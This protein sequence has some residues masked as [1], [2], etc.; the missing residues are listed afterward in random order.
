[1]K[2]TKRLLS[3]LL[4]VCM[5]L[6]LLPTVALFAGAAIDSSATWTQ[7]SWADIEDGATIIIAN[8]NHVALP[9]TTTSTNPTKV[10][11]TVSGS[12]GALTIT[13]ASGSLDSLAWTINGDTSSADGVQILQYGSTTVNLRLSSTSSNTALRVAATASDNKFVL[14]N[15]GRLL[16]LQTANRYVG[17]YVN[18]SDWRTYDSETAQNYKNQS[19]IF[20]KLNS[21]AAPA[22]TYTLSYSKNGAIATAD[23]A[24]GE[25]ISLPSAENVEDYHFVGWTA[26]QTVSGRPADLMPAGT[27]YTVNGDVMLYAVYAIA[28]E[29]SGDTF[30]LVDAADVIAGEYVIG[31]LRSEAATDAFYFA[32]GTV[33]SGDMVVTSDP[34]TVHAVNGIRTIGQSDLPSGTKIFTLTGD[35]AEGFAIGLDS[36]Y[37]GYTNGET[38]RTLDLGDYSSIRWTVLDSTKSPNLDEKGVHLR[39]GSAYTISENSTKTD[40]IRGYKGTTLYRPIYLFAR[41]AGGVG[42]SDYTTSPVEPESH[43]ITWLSEGETFAIAHW[44]DGDTILPPETNPVKAAADDKFYTFV[45][46]AATEGGELVTDFGVATGDRT[47]YAVFLE[48]TMC[49]VDDSAELTG[50]KSISIDVLAND[51][52]LPTDGVIYG[53]GETEADIAKR[54]DT[55]DVTISHYGTVTVAEGRVIY[56]PS[57]FVADGDVI[58]FYYAVQDALGGVDY[59]QV[60]VTARGM[61]NDRPDVEPGD[62]VYTL[63]TQN[64]VP[65]PEVY[66]F[67]GDYILMGRLDADL[68]YLNSYQVLTPKWDADGNVTI[69]NV[70]SDAANNASLVDLSEIDDQGVATGSILSAYTAEDVIRMETSGNEN[71]LDG[72][73]NEYTIL[74]KITAIDTR[75]AFTIELVDD[76]NRYYTIRIKD[77]N[78]YLANSNTA[79]AGENVMEY[80]NSA[81]RNDT[82]MLWTI[83][84]ATEEDGLSATDG[85]T[86]D[87]LL[88]EN[89]YGL[90]QEEAVSRAILYNNQGG[91]DVTANVN[92]ARFRIYGNGAYHNNDYTLAGA[93]GGISYSIYLFGAPVPFV[94]QIQQDGEVKTVA[95]PVT[96]SAGRTADVDLQS[97]LL[98]DIDTE[99]NYELTGAPVWTISGNSATANGA[100]IRL[101]DSNEGTFHIGAA[102]EGAYAYVTVTYTVYDKVND[103]THRVSTDARIVITAATQSF[104]GVIYTGAEAAPNTVS[105]NVVSGTLVALDYYVVDNMT[106]L[107]SLDTAC[108]FAVNTEL[109]SDLVWSAVDTAGTV[110]TVSYD[111][112]RGKWTVDTAGA[113]AGEIISVTMTGA[114][115]KL[116]LNQDFSDIVNVPGFKI[117]VVDTLQLVADTAILS[118]LNPLTMDV[119]ANDLNLYEGAVICGLGETAALASLLQTVNVPVGAYGTVSVAENRV[120]FSPGSAVKENDVITFYY[121]VQGQDGSYD[122]ARVTITVDGIS[123]EGILTTDTLVIDFGLPVSFRPTANDTGDFTDAAVVGIQATADGTASKA[124][125]FA[126]GNA[127][128]H[129]D[130]TVTFTPTGMMTAPVVFYYAVQYK[131]ESFAGMIQIVPATNVYYEDSMD[132]VFTF[133]PAEAWARIGTTASAEQ[134]ADFAGDIANGIYGYD[135]AYQRFATYSMG[136]AHVAT[137]DNTTPM[138]TV[139]FD[140]YGSGFDVV[141]LTGGNSGYLMVAICPYGSSVPVARYVVDTYYGFSYSEQ[142]EQVYREETDEEGNVIQVPVY[143]FT[144]VGQ[145]NGD[146]ELCSGAA[147]PDDA[148]VWEELNGEIYYYRNVGEGEGSYIREPLIHHW[149]VTPETAQDFYQIPVMKVMGLEPA[150]YTVT[151]ASYYNGF[152]DHVGDGSYQFV[153]DAVRVYDP[154]GSSSVATD[155]Y[156]ADGENAPHYLNL[157]DEILK[158]TAS[159]SLRPTEPDGE[160]YSGRYYLATRRNEQSNYFYMTDDLGSASTKRY[161]AADSGLMELPGEITAPEQGKVFVLELNVDGTYSIYREGSDSEEKYLGW[162]SGN[163]G[164]LVSR[165]QAAEITVRRQDDGT[166]H[167]FFGNRYLSLNASSSYNYF[168]WYEGTQKQ[169]L[170]LIPVTGEIEKPCSHE[171]IVINGYSAANCT[172][173]GYSGDT[174]CSDCGAVLARGNVIP[175]VGHSYVDG[176]CN[177]CG[178]SETE[179]KTRYYIATTRTVSGASSNY[180]YM[181]SELGTASTKRYQAVDSGLAVAPT[182]IAETDVITNRVFVLEQN[183]D[184]SY[185]IYTEGVSGDERYLGWSSGN[186]GILVRAENAVRAAVELTDGVYHI[187]FT[188]GDGERYLALNGTTGNHYFAWYKSGQEQDLTLIPIGSENAPDDGGDDIPNV[189]D[190]EYF[191]GD[192]SSKYTNVAANWGTRGEIATFLTGYAEIYYTGSNTY[193]RFASKSGSTSADAASLFGSELGAA[194]HDMLVS[195]Q[196]KITSYDDAKVLMAYTDCQENDITKLST[197]YSGATVSSTWDSGTTYNREHVWPNSKGLEGSDENDIMML[198]PEQSSQNSSRGNKAYGESAEFFYPNLSSSYDV[199]GDIARN[200]LQHFLRWGN[201]QYLWGS[202][203]VMEN[204][205]ILLKWIEEDPVDTWEMGRNDS[206]QTITGVRNVFV[207]YPELAFLLFNEAVPEGYVTPSTAA[208]E[209]V[210]KHTGETTTDTVEATCTAEGSVTVVCNDCGK[211]VS[212]QTIPALEHMYEA[213]IIAPLCETEGYTSYRCLRCG[214]SYTDNIVPATGHVNTTTTGEDATCTTEGSVTVTCNDCGKTVSSETIP[215]L[216]HMYEAAVI[217]PLCETEGYTSYR[218]LR[219][220]HSYTDNVVPATGHV[221]TATAVKDATCTA[222]GTVTVT[223]NDCGKTVSTETI[224]ATGHSYVHKNQG[225]Y[226]ISSC[227]NCGSSHSGQHSYVDRVCA[228]GAKLLRIYFQNNWNWSDI[229]IYYWYTKNGTDY[230]NA[231]WP[232]QK[233]TQVAGNSNSGYKVYVMEVPD[234]IKGMVFSGVKD[235]GSGYR[236]QSPDITSGWYDGGCYY[237]VW[238]NGNAVGVFPVVDDMPGLKASFTAA[239]DLPGD[240]AD[241]RPLEAGYAIGGAVRPVENTYAEAVLSGSCGA[242]GDNVTWSF[243]P[244]TGTLRLEGTGATANYTYNQY[245][246]VPTGTMPWFEFLDEIQHIEISDGITKL[247]NYVFRGCSKVTELNIP[248]SVTALGTHALS[249][250][251]GLT[252]LTI[253]G[254]VQT[255]G[256]SVVYSCLNLKTVTLE[257]A[258]PEISFL[259]FGDCIALTTVYCGRGL[260]T[261]GAGA[262]DGCGY[263]T[264]V[265]FGGTPAQWSTIVIG[266]G[267]PYFENATIHYCAHE[268]LIPTDEVVPPGCTEDGYTVCICATCDEMVNGYTVSAT[269][270]SYSVYTDIGDG[271]VAICD[272]GC[273]HSFAEEHTYVEGVCLCGSRFYEGNAMGIVFI[274]GN[275]AAELAEYEDH[276]P[277]NEIY[278]A[279]KQ[280][281]AFGLSFNSEPKSIHIGL[282]TIEGTG[283]ESWFVITCGSNRRTYKVTSAT[284]M[285]Y[286]ITDIVTVGQKEDGSYASAYP[287]IIT[288]TNGALGSLTYLKW[289]SVS[290]NTPTK[291]SASTILERGEIADVLDQVDEIVGNTQP[292]DG[293]AEVPIVP[294][295]QEE[296]PEAPIAPPVQ[297]ETSVIAVERFSD[298]DRNTWYYEGVAYAVENGLMKGMSETEFAPEGTLTRGMLVTILYR[299]AGAPAVEGA[300]PGFTDVTPGSWY[301][302]AVCWAYAE[303]ITTGIT[304]TEFA[305]EQAVS[306]QQ[307]VTFLWRA[308]GKPSATSGYGE[309]PAADAEKVAAYASTAMMWAWENGILKGE[310]GKL[311]PEDYATRAQIANI[312]MRFE[313]ALA[314]ASFM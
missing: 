282:K 263:L 74:D 95:N 285:Y 81:D 109:E 201:T 56:T 122:Y 265:Y 206:V 44:K 242:E 234:Y 120:V 69:E 195:K 65:A 208:S 67:T 70:G 197:Y 172:E 22:I 89:V 117:Y 216:E 290:A 139:S 261:V 203:G 279:K 129:E 1:M 277:N 254:S 252:Q 266:F 79:D 29:S 154:C 77:T 270:H 148:V 213:A 103:S 190:V 24:S 170:H 132:G 209:D 151:V 211:T 72:A 119:L 288:K 230:P 174:V 107:T 293:N 179:G 224:P 73:G 167:L 164:L 292:D 232:G 110:Y 156:I 94:A 106:S 248:S 25:T 121:S 299:Q 284:E 309:R 301:Y 64:N 5:V 80:T 157:H 135:D 310:N 40:A 9:N 168:A 61:Q 48:H 17:E 305:P 42:Y 36:S 92:T 125:D 204:A 212:T 145:G 165:E 225:D 178:G 62:V 312:F 85:Y 146:W 102:A 28:T 177:L 184:G 163:S 220:G 38:S 130:G 255:L 84:W 108:G 13:P 185:C 308:A 53:L 205:E 300:D 207:D 215:A 306:R 313:K 192:P 210:C 259:M 52:N 18:G 138:A 246:T 262:F 275:E 144:E 256:S 291:A 217:A 173:D 112:A 162:S 240:T 258:V 287:I 218:C 280:A 274:D 7:T 76:V 295:T 27:S 238:N 297:D 235:D 227:K 294:P 311:N 296:P 239:T 214:H 200:I 4:V 169:D 68:V 19:L 104:N 249:H 133:D 272:N 273:G 221:D 2:L 141:S 49:L 286:D 90:Q 30:M 140:F 59:A 46:W 191:Y 152:Y 253:P 194:L 149:I 260:K 183:D 82:T 45:G 91:H 39:N 236:D 113:A 116:D 16:K 58:V 10:G 137:V 3:M 199:R 98:P 161:Q 159:E 75:Y 78:Y 128:L 251:N 34:V 166:F 134:S 97:L 147:A 171:D 66:N 142:G 222:D 304:A 202:E 187:H 302:D 182:Y 155:A 257:A 33:S 247:G 41:T 87:V 271:H 243:D 11:I 314:F 101:T 118:D 180:F 281:V 245:A 12:A 175:A 20:Y 303:G 131:E 198:R 60:T 153:F 136:S 37:L 86:P 14:G 264:D 43:T 250:M 96:V 63:V 26:S 100:E 88:I 150:L 114:Q 35:Q 123:A 226:H 269:G 83:R 54:P 233:M 268:T 32:T 50:Y 51:R 126:E 276:G 196:T 229:R 47:F 189:G 289:T 31:A 23:Y 160:D 99:P 111:E 307:M 143:V 8:T 231:T 105:Q 193:E 223:C 186:S 127:L 188:A 237:M 283:S 57:T 15:D 241:P 124:L 115:A 158:E 55:S 71:I 6:S 244:A 21:G 278:L 176:I 93:S 228:C 298:L 219:C 181:T 267:N